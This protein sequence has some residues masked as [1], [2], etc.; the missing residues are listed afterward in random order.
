MDTAD[1]HVLQRESLDGETKN[2]VRTED[3]VERR[4]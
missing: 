1:A 2:I 3:G 4:Y